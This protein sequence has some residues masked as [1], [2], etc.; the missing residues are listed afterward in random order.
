MNQDQNSNVKNLIFLALT[1]LGV[2]HEGFPL[3]HTIGQANFYG[4]TKREQ[5]D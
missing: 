4:K 3:Y 5:L 2:D 1:V